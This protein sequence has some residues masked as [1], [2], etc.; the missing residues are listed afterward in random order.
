MTTRKN[1]PEK[2]ERRD[3]LKKTGTV[4]AIV[5]G[6]PGIISGQ[7]VTNSLKVGLV[8]CGGR[9]SG[10]ARQ[11]LTADPNNEL[12][13]IADVDETIVEQATTRLK[14]STQIGSRV[15][16]DR[17]YVGLDAYEKVINSG[18]RRHA[19]D[20]AWLPAAASDRRHQCQQARV[21]REAVC[22]RLTWRPRG[23]GG[24]EARAVEEPLARRRVLLA[25]QQH[26]SGG[27]RAG[28]QR[29]DWPPGRALLDLLH[30]PGQAPAARDHASGG[31]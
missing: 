18:R 24:A 15:K 9:G 28:A 31:R 8:G 20:A 29:R 1:E 30:Q 14:G 25:L 16:I 4:A 11:A 17:A 10:A 21:L 2:I 19:R 23:H 22:D 7:S 5:A 27:D 3:F 6:F 13:A 26:D 12:T